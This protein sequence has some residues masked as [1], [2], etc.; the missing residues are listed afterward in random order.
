MKS[1]RLIGYIVLI[2][3]TLGLASGRLLF[4]PMESGDFH[5]LPVALGMMTISVFL[6]YLSWRKGSSPDRLAVYWSFIF[7]LGAVQISG[8]SGSLLFP[9]LLLFLA[10]VTLPGMNGS[11]VELGVIAGATG[12][13][14]LL[15]SSIGSGSEPFLTRLLPLLPGCLKAF[16]TPALFGFAI[17]WLSERFMKDLPQVRSSRSSS[18]GGHRERGHSA[19]EEN[20][21]IELLEMLHRRSGAD[22]TCL[23]MS[24]DP[25]FLRLEHFVGGDA[26]ISKCLL[27]TGHR[28]VH[29]LG[30]LRK[31]VSARVDSP[32]ERRDLLPYRRQELDPEAPV[33]L[34]VCPLIRDDS[35]LGFLLQDFTSQPPPGTAAELESASRIIGISPSREAGSTRNPD[36]EVSWITRMI[37]ACD[38]GPLDRAVSSIAGLLQQALPDSTISIA[39]VEPS[40]GRTCV[41]VSRGPLAGSR[42]EKTCTGT[43]IAG[44]IVKNR[45]PCR[46]TGLNQGERSVWAFTGGSE[47]SPGSLNSCMGAPIIVEGEV[48]GLIMAEHA[49]DDAYGHEHEG[50]LFA[51]AGLLSMKMELSDLRGRCGD[52]IEGD[53]LTGLPRAPY[54]Y[55]NLKMMAGKVQLYGGPVSVIVADIDDFSSLNEKVGYSAGDSILRQAALRF[56]GC[57]SPE[58][59]VARIGS[60]R[61][62]ACVPSIDGAGLEALI[63]RTIN[64]LSWNFSSGAKDPGV[65]VSA[66]IGA[67]YTSTNKEVLL[68]IR[69]AERAAAEAAA[70]GPGSSRMKS[71]G[72]GRGPYSSSRSE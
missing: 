72:R 32:N 22:V 45:T 19:P 48:T 57:F 1:L 43:G 44:W 52:L 68:L 14:A 46:R 36:D 34:M 39:D 5:L 71:L 65:A 69:E 25:D 61:F 37:T 30:G 49:D 40:T 13:I 41:W 50:M 60:D 59:I 7:I 62:A 67:C 3:A 42:R 33:W 58:I 18:R 47:E 15:V 17:E 6:I 35:V 38:Q 21:E 54:L 4:N 53:S 16:L 66:S 55:D 70:A 56:S 8:G 2:A 29:M 24:Y 12:A 63:A 20:Y 10:G 28:L 26:V 23:F 31:T 51:A 64:A 11:A 27:P 9:V